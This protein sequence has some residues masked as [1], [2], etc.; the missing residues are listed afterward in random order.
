MSRRRATRA[1]AHIPK[2]WEDV[3]ERA[4]FRLVNLK[5]EFDVPD[6]VRSPYLYECKVAV[7]D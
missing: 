5:K 1:A 6:S 3:C 4:F 7:V 2:D